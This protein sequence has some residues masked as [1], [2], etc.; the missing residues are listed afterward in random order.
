[1]SRPAA[2]I[3]VGSNTV[4]LV[5]ARRESLPTPVHTDKATPGLGREIEACGRLSGTAIAT[6]ADTVRRFCA[7]ARAHGAASIEVLVTA[8]GRQAENGAELVE[9]IE[10]AAGI[11]VRVLSPEEEAEFAFAGAV[12]VASPSAPVVAVVDLGGAS[13]ELAV[14][15]AG[16]GPSWVR[17][18][19]L[20]A[21]RLTHR[22]LDATH[23]APKDVEA[24]REAVAEAF[25][26]VTPPLPGAAL[27]VGGSVRALGRVVGRCLARGE[28]A[29]AAS[30]LPA[31]TAEALVERFD[32]S[33]QR[34]PL[35]L[36][37][38]L[39]LSEVQQRLVVPLEVADG[40]VREGALL[41]GRRE[42]KAA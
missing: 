1:V 27:A 29:A 17:S 42:A 6:T 25:S 37:A 8:P 41:L 21:V 23:P 5:V 3:D 28:L 39:I 34:A 14:G 13:T 33:K 26:G 10:R 38:A 12:A 35:L 15:C 40:G 9:A 22:L 32:V 18:V 2:V 16:E 7:D 11:L 20:G 24:A 4:R 31:C 36:A 19:D 30:I